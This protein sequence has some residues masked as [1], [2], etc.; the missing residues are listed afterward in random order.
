[1]R[2]RGHLLHSGITR[3]FTCRM[4]G[5]LYYW[6]RVEVPRSAPLW[7]LT[8]HT[9][10]QQ[11]RHPQWIACSGSSSHAVHRRSALMLSSLRSRGCVRMVHRMEVGMR[12][13]RPLLIIR[14][15]TQA[16]R[17]A[18]LLIRYALCACTESDLEGLQEEETTLRAWLSNPRKLAVM[19]R[20]AR[21]ATRHGARSKHQPQACIFR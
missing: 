4:P 20:Q 7:L 17:A 13:F 21:R 6:V 15:R 18:R 8:F 5:P 12:R 14:S 10:Y 9:H 1:L 2:P 16:E 3:A 11:S 19:T